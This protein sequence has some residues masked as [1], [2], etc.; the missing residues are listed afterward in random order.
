MT[1]LERRYRLLLR[2]YPPEHRR[3]HEEE[4]LGVLLADTDRSWPP[5]RDALDLVRGGLW[6]RLRHAPRA[7][8]RDTAALLSVLAPVVLFAAAVRYAV[9]V[10][11]M[12]PELRYAASRGTSWFVM[13]YSAPSWFLWAGAAVAAWAGARRTAA[14][15]VLVAIAAS[16]ATFIRLGDHG[17]GVAAAPLLLGLITVTSL[18]LGA[19]PARGRELLGRSVVIMMI[20]V[21]VL[22]AS[23]GS[24]LLMRTLSVA[25]G[26]ALGI[27]A[28]AVV[29]AGWL[30][31]RHGA[32]GRRAAVVLAVPLSPV[33]LPFY[34]VS[35][36]GTLTRYL[37][38]MVAL[39]AAACVAGLAVITVLEH[40]TVRPES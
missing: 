2:A 38:T 23:L 14:V 10:A 34:P 19:A 29:A 40:L 1:A 21:P 13:L 25:P 28:I 27:Q 31:V 12:F 35:I 32:A 3:T 6:V 18:I 22:V 36:D 4:M 20:A 24:P 17:G 8:W 26:G 30:V 39:P 15:A 16:L 37:V 33:F 11:L 5:V 7:K 9:R